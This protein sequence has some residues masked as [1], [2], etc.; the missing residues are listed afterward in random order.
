MASI[1]RQKNWLR[2][3]KASR[4]RALRFRCQSLDFTVTT[5]GLQLCF[6]CHGCR[7]LQTASGFLATSTL[8]STS[9]P[10]L[11]HLRYFFLSGPCLGPYTCTVSIRAKNHLAINTISPR[12]WANPPS[13]P[14]P[15][16]PKLCPLDPKPY[17][18]NF[19]NP[20]L[21]WRGPAFPTNFNP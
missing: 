4:C 12:R 13:R 14:S 16:S 1:L 18:Y 20:T 3:L 2:S 21:P 7:Q 5:V 19:T 6:R 9:L 10:L 15:G 11:D 17:A 8:R